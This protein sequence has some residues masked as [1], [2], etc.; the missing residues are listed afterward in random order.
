MRIT[1]GSAADGDV[2]MSAA[3]GEVSFSAE[4]FLGI[5]VKA[6]LAVAR[7]SRIKKSVAH[8]A[9]SSAAV[10]RA[11]YAAALDLHLH[12]ARHIACRIGIAAEAAAAAE[13]VA[14]HIRGAPGADDGTA[15]RHGL[16]A[17]TCR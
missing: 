8:G 15:R 14:V 2:D 11:K 6:H 16:R 3:L 7:H 10:D 4:S 13:D 9:E 12:T 1:D 5:I 17:L